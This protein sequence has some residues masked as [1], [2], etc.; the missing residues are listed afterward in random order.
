MKVRGHEV[1]GTPFDATLRE[2]LPNGVPPSAYQPCVRNVEATQQA[3]GD[4]FLG[5]R[6]KVEPG[7][8]PVSQDGRKP[9]PV[10][11]FD[12][13]HS[14][15]FLQ[16]RG[17]ADAV[18][19]VGAGEDPSHVMVSLMDVQGGVQLVPLG[20]VGHEARKDIVQI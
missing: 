13:H 1:E 14:A 19:V 6:H 17:D 11:V 16:R 20:L 15:K 7:N 3:D 4:V 10:V 5:L 8:E 2:H 9:A 12:L 18:V